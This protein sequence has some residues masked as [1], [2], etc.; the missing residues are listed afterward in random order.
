MQQGQHI[1]KLAISIRDKDGCVIVSEANRVKMAKKLNLDNSASYLLVGGLGGLGRSVSR[2]LV[3]NDA[4]RLLFLSR[5]SGQS[6]D[7]AEFVRE[8]ESMGCEVVLIKGSVT[9]SDDVAYAV[10]QAGPSLRGILQCTM[11]L[12]DVGFMQMTIDDWHA[13]SAPKC[14]VHGSCMRPLSR[15]ASPSTSSCSFPRCLE[16]LAHQARPIMLVRTHSSMLSYSTG[17]I[18][19]WLR[20]QSTLS[21]HGRW[22][23]LPG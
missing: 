18:L 14:A 7:H 5:S 23:R 22:R 16:P 12:R 17:P 13:A 11:V 2:L 4:R 6:P 21:C 19:A 8:M 15:P 20:L 9:N 3:E 10:Q 1:G